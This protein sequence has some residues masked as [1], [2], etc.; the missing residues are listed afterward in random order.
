LQDLFYDANI[1]GAEG[2]IEK[3]KDAF[4]NKYLKSGL[5]L[6]PVTENGKTVLKIEIYKK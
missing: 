3:E 2:Q 5:L 4:F 1:I 6:K